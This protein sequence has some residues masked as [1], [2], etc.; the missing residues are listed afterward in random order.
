[1]R[2]LSRTTK[3][4]GLLLCLTVSIVAAI[5]ATTRTGE[6]GSTPPS[7][8]VF[9]V[10]FLGTLVLIRALKRSDVHQ[11]ESGSSMH[12][13]VRSV[14]TG[15]GIAGIGYMVGFLGAI[16]IAGSDGARIVAEGMLWYVLGGMLIVGAIELATRI[17]GSKS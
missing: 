11:A 5:D 4:V 9:F 1:M 7:L 16:L 15:L 6:I 8:Y 10:G 12:R 2:R 14:L 17:R 13:T 3:V